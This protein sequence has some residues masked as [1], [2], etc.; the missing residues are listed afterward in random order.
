MV[1]AASC[2][3]KGPQG[4]RGWMCPQPRPLLLGLVQTPT[5]MPVSSREGWCVSSAS[6]GTVPGFPAHAPSG[7]HM[8][9]ETR[10]PGFTGT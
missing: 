1:I 2:V 4:G 7:V 3:G 9:Q 8:G 5:Q 10:L 6:W